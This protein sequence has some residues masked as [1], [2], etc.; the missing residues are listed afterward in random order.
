[1]NEILLVAV[2]IFGIWCAI[3]DK[4]FNAMDNDEDEEDF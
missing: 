3:D 4:F 2:I 1:M